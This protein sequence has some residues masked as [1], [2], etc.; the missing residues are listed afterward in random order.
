MHTVTVMF[1][2]LLVTISTVLAWSLAASPSSL[3][4]LQVGATT[5]RNV[6]VLRVTDTDLYFQHAEGIANVKLRDLDEKMQKQFDYDPEAAREAE[7][8]QLEHDSLY[9]KA[10]AQQTAQRTTDSPQA[11]LK[12]L[13]RSEES[14]ADPVSN[15]SLLGKPAP[16]LNV[17]RWLDEKPE[18]QGRFVLV[19]F[20]APWSAPS[21]KAIPTLNAIQKKFADR[22]TVIGL[23]A[24]SVED[25]QSLAGARPQFPCGVDTGA[26]MFGAAGVTSVPSVLLV[27][28]EGTVLYH[29]HPAA[30]NETS[31]QPIIAGAA[32]AN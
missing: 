11:A 2:V 1:R 27:H 22:L 16:S 6:K 8:R 20:W 12:A 26:K 9:H 25:I 28:P 19:Y 29:G 24:E 31:L 30:L 4:T 3:D 7:R 32:N 14:L 5:Y 17:D 10:Q 15:G 13:V 23:C 18:T 21:R